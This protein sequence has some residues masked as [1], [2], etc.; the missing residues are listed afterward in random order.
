MSS[1]LSSTGISTNQGR[2]SE[3][4]VQTQTSPGP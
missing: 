2:S 1:F 4:P 3:A